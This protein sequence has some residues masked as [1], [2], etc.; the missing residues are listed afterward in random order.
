MVVDD[1]DGGWVVRM[2]MGWV[3]WLGGGVCGEN[4]D[5]DGAAG[6]VE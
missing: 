1:E 2:M 4:D 3:V 5:G 6:K